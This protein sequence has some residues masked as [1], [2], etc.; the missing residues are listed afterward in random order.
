MKGL[1]S[2]IGLS[3]VGYFSMVIAAKLFWF[4]Y[5]YP[6]NPSQDEINL[7]WGIHIIAE[8]LFGYL[9]VVLTSIYVTYKFRLTY[10]YKSVF[11]AILCAISYNIIGGIIWM[12]QFGYEPYFKHSMPAK[13][14][15]IV[16]VLSG[17]VSLI[18]Y[19]WLPNK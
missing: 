18:S 5:P 7:V 19:K 17:V 1:V 8:K 6:N 15:L 13:L 3:A 2:I 4:V 11:L 16:I 14:L 10:G 9:V 12:L